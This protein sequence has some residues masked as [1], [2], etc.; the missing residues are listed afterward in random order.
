MLE[1]A[2]S[3]FLL[4]WIVYI[5]FFIVVEIISN[6]YETRF[7]IKVMTKIKYFL[8]QECLN[9]TQSRN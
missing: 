5:D 8:Y 9:Y 6:I 3:C 7:V 2:L 4:S 1:L